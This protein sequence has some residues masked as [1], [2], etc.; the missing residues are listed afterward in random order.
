MNV[1]KF[2]ADPG[3]SRALNLARPLGPQLAQQ[4]IGKAAQGSQPA[5]R[6][7]AP[8]P[9][10]QQ[11]VS[12]GNNFSGGAPMNMPK[13]AQAVSLVT[14]QSPVASPS[15]GSPQAPAVQMP[16]MPMAPQPQPALEGG[17]GDQEVFRIVYPRKGPDGT[18]YLAEFD[19]FFPRGTTALGS[20]EVKKVQ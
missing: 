13:G 12:Q 9:M 8:Q 18:T 20:P 16:R 1:E 11:P 2:Q 10:V 17:S 14:S 7:A 4:P 19:A 3:N 5:V 15:L 6:Q